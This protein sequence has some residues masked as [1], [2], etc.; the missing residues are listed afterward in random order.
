M[1]AQCSIKI[2]I[3]GSLT[4]AGSSNGSPSTC[5]ATNSSVIP[6]LMVSCYL[7]VNHGNSGRASFFP[8]S[9][10]PPPL[11]NQ[12]GAWGPQCDSARAKRDAPFVRTRVDLAAIS[13]I[14]HFKKVNSANNFPIKCE[15]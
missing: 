5:M 3:T 8:Q 12:E 13:P 15:G 2:H 4:W 10:R 14:G 1:S 6:D 11:V 9:A 7:M